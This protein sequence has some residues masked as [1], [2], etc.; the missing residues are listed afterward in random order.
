MS[1]AT[2]KFLAAVE[3]NNKKLA[4]GEQPS[5]EDKQELQKLAHFAA[6]EELWDEYQKVR[7]ALDDSRKRIEAL[8][9]TVL[10][11]WAEKGDL[12][13]KGKAAEATEVEKR[14]KKF[15]AER[16]RIQEEMNARVAGQSK[17]TGSLDEV[18]AR[19]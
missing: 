19:V 18:R 1:S 8:H 11:L 3:A 5:A 15:R 2:E 10:Q 7:I 12:E 16:N 13:R 14:L 6:R 17:R 4:R 9:K